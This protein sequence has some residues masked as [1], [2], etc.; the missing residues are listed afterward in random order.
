M[1]YIEITLSI[2]PFEEYIADIL[3]SEL[4]EIGFDSFVPTENGLIA[5][6]QESD[7]DKQKLENLIHNF[8]LAEKIEYSIQHIP[9]KNWNEE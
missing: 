6:A 5:Y 8:A 1:N 2:Q 9:Q 3:A 4:G 7:F